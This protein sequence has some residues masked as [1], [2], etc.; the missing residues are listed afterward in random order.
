LHVAGRTEPE[1]TVTLNGVHI[2]VQRDGSF[3]EHVAL[4]ERN[5]VVSIRATGKSGATI[6][7]RL[8]V[9]AGR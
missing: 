9:V 1:V 8:P 4:E 6:E 7:Q 3:N 5:A 2:P